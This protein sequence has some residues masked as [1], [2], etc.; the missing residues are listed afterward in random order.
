M[1]DDEGIRNNR[2]RKHK[3]EELDA[4]QMTGTEFLR[5]E[6]RAKNRRIEYCIDDKY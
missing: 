2:H 6:K 1:Y 3:I 5:R 4:V